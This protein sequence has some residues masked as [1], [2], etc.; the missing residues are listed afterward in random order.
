MTAVTLP[1]PVA[2]TRPSLA[3]LVRVELRKTADTRA[4]LWLLLVIGLLALGVVVIQLVAAE[5]RGLNFQRF[6]STAQVPVAILL[7]VLGILAV[8]SEWSQRTA[9]TTFTLVPQ[10]L[11]IVAAKLI[12]A[13]LLSLLASVACLA[14]AAAGNLLAPLAGDADGSWAVSATLVGNTVLFQMLNVLMGVAFGMLL[15]SSPVAIVLY[16]VIPTAFSVLTAL[17]TALR[18]AAE[19]LDFSITMLPLLEG[20]GLTQGQWAR[21]AASTGLWLAL[22]LLLGVLRIQRSEVS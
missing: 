18:T 20:T 8:T 5:P 7:P 3:R 1:A 10:R 14:A 16:F 2:P 4:G 13:V 21:L 22:P 12:A 19:W 9:L 11:R 15:L 6:L 17:V